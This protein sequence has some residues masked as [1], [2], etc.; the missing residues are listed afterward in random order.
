MTWIQTTLQ[1]IWASLVAFGLIKS[2][3]V[4]VIIALVSRAQKL[5]GLVAA[6]LFIAFLAHW[7]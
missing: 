2:I 1:T 3:I 7:I 5:L 6:I 4:V